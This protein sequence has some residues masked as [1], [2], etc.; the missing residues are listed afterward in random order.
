MHNAYNMYCISEYLCVHV[1]CNHFCLC[2]NHYVIRVFISNTCL[3][4]SVVTNAVLCEMKI[5]PARRSCQ[6]K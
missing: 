5:C 4:Y 6:N 3:F 1:D 2:V